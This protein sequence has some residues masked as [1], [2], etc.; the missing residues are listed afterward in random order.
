V[1]PA[2]AARAEAARASPASRV[3]AAPTRTLPMAAEWA[4]VVEHRGALELSAGAGRAY[5]SRMSTR[6]AAP[7]RQAA[8]ARA[9]L[10]DTIVYRMLDAAARRCD[11]ASVEV[12]ARTVYVGRRVVVM[13]DVTAP[14]AGTMDAYFERIGQE[15]DDVQFPIVEAN[16]GSPLALDARTD[17]NGRVV[18]L[19]TRQVNERPGVLGLVLSCD[20]VPR[21]S[22]AT[23]SNEAEIIYA[24]VP[25]NPAAGFGDAA[26]QSS[27]IGT[28]DAWRRRI[29]TTLVHELKHVASYA[30]RFAAE[31]PFEE[32]WLEE[33][34][35]LVAEELWARTVYGNTLRGNATYSSTIACDLRPTSPACVDA[36]YALHEHFARLYD[37]LGSIETLS[38]LLTDPA[39]D[40]RQSFYASS[41]WLLRY[42]IDQT[43]GTD[44]AFLR[45]L[46]ASQS[47]GVAN[48]VARAGRAWPTLLAEW[49]LASAVDDLPGLVPQRPQLTVPS[50]NTRDIFAGLHT[51]LAGTQGARF[52]R[53]F[54]LAPRLLTFGDFGA[55][56]AIT[57][58]AGSAAIFELSGAQSARQLLELRGAT[59]GPP[60]SS[61]SMSIVRVQ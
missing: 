26:S 43:G 15:F 28:R 51:D 56:D 31:A 1:P 5:A 20:F 12:R 24:A 4:R 14:L 52:A 57:V 18:L 47:T 40:P 17:R 37:Y 46:V 50:W 32:P 30:Q 13:E 29:R 33:G 21:S 48:L 39:L 49:T 59:G 7:A 35:A 23:A 44:A 34:T 42:A 61:L 55:D 11:A 53:R 8:A 6:G 38:P 60:P 9:S 58:S 36:P 3:R 25:T 27:A 41:W 19:F 16:F 54:P 10:G 2:E 45:P 22:G